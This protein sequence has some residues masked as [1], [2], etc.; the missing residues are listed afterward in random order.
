MEEHK[1]DL[2]VFFLEGDA[3]QWWQGVL[4][5]DPTEV[6]LWDSFK[7]EF[8]RKY[9]P[10][11]ARIKL[12]TVFLELR[13][14]ARSIRD[15]E[16]EFNRLKKYAGREMDIEQRQV[17]RF[18]RG[19]KPELMTMMVSRDYNTVGE[20]VKKASLVESGLEE[21]AK[22]ECS[23]RNQV[24]SRPKRVENQAVGV[25]MTACGT[26]GKMHRGVCH[27]CI[28]GCF[29]CGSMD[30]QIRDCPDA[31]EGKCYL[32]GDTGHLAR[33]CRAPR[34]AQAAR[35]RGE[36]PEGDQQQPA[37]RQNVAPRVHMLGV[38]DG[39]NPIDGNSLTFHSLS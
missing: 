12:E 6:H 38:E 21:L 9:F 32:C 16:H 29:K 4:R 22:H 1:K 18:M 34:N 37:K 11:E 13:Q 20:L 24:S 27:Q 23:R 10:T 25:V 35:T 28:S 17:E 2:A 14:G 15:Y 8:T 7:E 3:Y 39:A 31:G 30:H 33:D 36:R 5:R 26:C 19:M